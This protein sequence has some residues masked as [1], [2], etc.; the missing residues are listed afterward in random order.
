MFNQ[1]K[2]MCHF[3]MLSNKS[4]HMQNILRSCAPRRER[5]T[6]PRKSS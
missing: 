6:Y 4:H 3:L 1:V 5:R 2:I